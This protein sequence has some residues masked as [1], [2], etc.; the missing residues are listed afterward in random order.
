MLVIHTLFHNSA[1]H[2]GKVSRTVLVLRILICTLFFAAITAD[3]GAKVYYAN[4]SAIRAGAI[5][6][7]Q[8]VDINGRHAA[9]ES[10]NRARLAGTLS[11]LFAASGAIVWILARKGLKGYSQ[12]PAI[13]LV[14]IWAFL[15][16]LF[17]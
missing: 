9:E 6:P 8:S 10:L 7:S 13:V 12:L 17:V 14:L 11:Y 5:Q 4:R 1:T 16:F 15:Q 3:I 2:L